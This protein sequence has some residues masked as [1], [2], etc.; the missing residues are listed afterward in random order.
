M[1]RKLAWVV[2]LV[3]A[4]AP[5]GALSG[6]LEV[7]ALFDGGALL[8]VAG[9]HKLLRVGE[10]FAGYTLIEVTATEAVVEYGG[11]RHVKRIV[12]RISSDYQTPERRQT[13][14]QRNAQQQYRTRA[15]INRRKVEVLVD[16]G[17][18][19]V[20]MSTGHAR[21]LGIDLSSSLRGQVETAG[22]RVLARIVSLESVEVGG[23]RVDN[24]RAAVLDGDNPRTIL[25]GM[26]Y[27]SHLDMKEDRGILLLS[28]EW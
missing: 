4:V 15:L 2:V 10:S 9:K 8:E 7:Q 16:T 6:S 12:R 11:Q 22:G 26:S 20:A 13:T 24:V 1:A 18:N 23:I 21:N 5:F 27:L 19:V 14:I 28:R 3:L 25:L 17:A